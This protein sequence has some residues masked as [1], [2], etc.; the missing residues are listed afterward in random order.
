MEDDRSLDVRYTEPSKEADSVDRTI[1]RLLTVISE[2]YFWWKLRKLG[3]LDDTAEYFV[4][5][6][7]VQ[8]QLVSKEP[9]ID[10][11]GF[12][13]FTLKFSHKDALPLYCEKLANTGFAWGDMHYTVYTFNDKHIMVNPRIVPVQEGCA[14]PKRAFGSTYHRVY[15]IRRTDGLVK[16]PQVLIDLDRRDTAAWPK[17][18]CAYCWE[19]GH[20]R[21]YCPTRTEWMRSGRIYYCVLCLRQNEHLSHL[22]LKNPDVDKDRM[23]DLGLCYEVRH[24]AE[25]RAPHTVEVSEDYMKSQGAQVHLRA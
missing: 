10:D 22:C 6:G 15:K 11:Q 18:R 4:E 19:Y 14:A 1:K 9:F 8:R 24:G 7:G 23:E 5:A 25:G 16:I 3:M 20:T 12:A 13:H 17:N 2:E 21:K